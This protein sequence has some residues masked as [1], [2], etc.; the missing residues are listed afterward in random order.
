MNNFLLSRQLTAVFL[1]ATAFT[2]TADDAQT[3]LSEM[4]FKGD[5]DDHQMRDVIPFEAI[6]QAPVLNV[7]Q[8][9]NTFEL[10][11]GFKIENVAA[12]PFLF[13]PV[14]L[15]FD[16]KGRIWVCEMTRYMENLTGS[17]EDKADGTIAILEDTDND[18]K[19]DK[20]SVFLND[21]VLPR[22]ISLVKGGIFYADQQQLYFTEIIEENGEIKPGIREIVDPTYA[23]GGN[24]EH[25]ANT[26][27]YAM[28][29][30]Y[31]NAKSDRKYQVLP[32]DA[33]LETG[34]AEIYR[35]QYW[36]LA[37]ASTDYR[38]QW[39]LTIDDSGYLYHN[40]N[41]SP[42][43]G[44]YLLPGELKHNP[45][46]WPKVDA[47]SIGPS[48]I[49]P[50]RMNPG[51]NR[52]Y[53]DGFLHT[54]QQNYGKLVNFTAASGSVIYRGDNFPANYYGLAITP[55]PAANLISARFIK[56]ADGILSGEPAFPG[57]ELLTSTDERFRP[58]NL[59]TAPD[60]SLYLADMYHGI[61]QHKEFLT[62]YLA[63]QIVARDLDKNNNNMGRIYRVSWK[64][65][66]LEHT[67]N[68][69][70]LSAEQ[71]IPYLTHANGWYRDT[72]RRLIIQANQ[73]N[74]GV[75]I[76]PLIQLNQSA[77]GVINVLWTLYGLNQLDLTSLQQIFNNPNTT[78]NVRKT[79]IA[80]AKKLP[81]EQHNSFVAMLMPE[82]K[83]YELA[84]QA[85]TTSA[86]LN[87]A[88]V[89]DLLKRILDEHLNKPYIR[90]AV[91]S[92][93]ADRAP[94]FLAH[95]N[96]A[97]PD[98]EFMYL[99][100]NLGKKPADRTNRAQLSESGKALYDLGKT[101]FNGKGGCTGCHGADG[102][103]LSGIGPTFWNSE[104][105]LDSKPRL[106]KILLHG[107]QGPIT[108]G[109]QTWE[110][111]VVMPGYAQRQDISDQELAAIAT[112]IRNSW[113]NAADTKS[114][115]T[116]DFIQQIRIQ[117]K[118]RS[119]PYKM[120]DLID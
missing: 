72:A 38:G 98:D 56:K 119:L 16:Q 114:H 18:G 20:R 96:G 80:V 58:V 33:P 106:A 88:N 40:G 1:L 101:L 100:N 82:I 25:K 90:S 39:G 35:N 67:V 5:Y 91:V 108:I 62:S 81:A 4:T 12:E 13:N 73:P 99:I 92:G 50:A 75:K 15:A 32:H 59:Y 41:S 97:Y 109:W 115:I 68:L 95:L 61:L 60:G 116:A 107:M 57:H 22:T 113:G 9:L 14:A 74:I 112:Y 84:L 89:L 103:G 69:A 48:A 37:R 85:A 76:K 55:E 29:N 53:L 63:K 65:K 24:V 104:W 70:G 93:L 17:T 105:V 110:T 111:S 11:K 3:D 21:I 102:S 19:I 43:Q 83:N 8:A 51:V 54:D 66:K 27:L 117:T 78:Q 52:G 44:E 120:E 36:K 86:F 26:M 49:Y 30:W 7:E 71:L 77:T 118:Q 64:N 2:A 42:V 28:D 34:S 47:I 46:F 6:P 45:G 79:I 94:K 23:E 10:A 87:S 31:Y